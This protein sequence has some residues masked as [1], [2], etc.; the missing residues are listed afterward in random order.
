M[1]RLRQAFDPEGRANPHKV[2]PDAKVCV[3][4]RQPRRQAAM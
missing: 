3:E 1:I 4:A 2:F